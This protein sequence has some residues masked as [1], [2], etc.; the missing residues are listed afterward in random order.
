MKCTSGALFLA[1]PQQRL[2][3]LLWSTNVRLVWFLM[4][5]RLAC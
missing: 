3:S 5:C 2:V 1:F 4:S